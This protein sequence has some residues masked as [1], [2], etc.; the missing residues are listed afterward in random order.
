MSVKLEL[1]K[2]C[3][4]YW[5]GEE[6]GKTNCLCCSKYPVYQASFTAGH[7]E[8]K[9]KG[10]DDI[11]E[12]IRPICQSCNNGMGT[13]NMNEYMKE[14]GFILR[15]KEQIQEEHYSIK[16][17]NL[18][19]IIEYIKIENLVLKRNNEDYFKKIVEKEL[20]DVKIK[21]L[22]NPLKD[23][24]QNENLIKIKDVEIS[25]LNLEIITL[26]ES[27][28]KKDLELNKNTEQHSKEKDELLRTISNLT[29]S[30]AMKLNRIDYLTNTINDMKNEIKEM[31]EESEYSSDSDTIEHNISRGTKYKIPKRDKC[32]CGRA[33]EK[34]R[35]ISNSKYCGY[36]Y[37]GY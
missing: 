4:D 20:D 23:N 6:I 9:S 14:H 36:H 37:G 5:I 28:I 2:Q 24:T 11:K 26:K 3:W 15:T 19:K 13:T 17:E 22:N 10:G 29:E 33:N 12:N 30:N 7:V 35:G 32:I 31:E 16:T 1:K 21:Q 18:Q 27:L 34:S 8:A 25:K